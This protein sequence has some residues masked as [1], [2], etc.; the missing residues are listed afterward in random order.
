LDIDEFREEVVM[1]LT[2]CRECGANISAE[3]EVCPNCGVRSPTR[4]DEGH[5]RGIIAIILI[6]GFAWILAQLRHPE[7][8]SPTKEQSASQKAEADTKPSA[9]SPKSARPAKPDNPDEWPDS[10]WPELR[11][12]R[13][14]WVCFDKSTPWPNKITR[15]FEDD[16]TDGIDTPANQRVWKKLIGEGCVPKAR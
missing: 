14:Q 8:T 11:H 16:G 2:P 3:A 9:P 12:Y 7:T 5:R 13:P 6:L 4:N 15:M 1:A 10:P